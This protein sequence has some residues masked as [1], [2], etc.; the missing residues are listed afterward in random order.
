MHFNG[1]SLPLVV[2]TAFNKQNTL[3]QLNRAGKYQPGTSAEKARSREPP[4][5]V[6]LSTN[7]AS[8]QLLI[9]SRIRVTASRTKTAETG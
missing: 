8:I 9:V 7:G 1:H 5:K 2:A 4:V 3:V 6:R